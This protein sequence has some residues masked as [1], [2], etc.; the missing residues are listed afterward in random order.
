VVG[1]RPTVALVS[2]EVAPFGGGGIGRYV[3]ALAGLLADEF[4]V[5]IFTT[6]RHREAHD[7]ARR[8]RPGSLPPARLVFVREPRAW[9]ARS[10]FSRLHA[11]SARVHEA[12]L[13]E[14]EGRGPDLA[15]FA[16]FLGEGCVTVQAKRTGSPALLETAVCVRIHGSAEVYDVLDGFL[17]ADRERSFTHELERYSVRY[18]DALLWAGGDILGS[19][20]RFYG[21]GEL[22]P[23]RLVRHP[24]EWSAAA[25]PASLATGGPLRLLYL[26]RLERRKGVRELVDA[27]LGL[28]RTGWRLTMVG[29]DTETAPLGGSMRELLCLEIAGDDR[30]ELVESVPREQV[31]ALLDGHDALVVPS[32][33]E[34]WPYVALEAMARGRPLV[35][36]PTGGLC[37]LVADGASGWL[38]RD[39]SVDGLAGAL[40][41]LV[42]RPRLAREDHDAEAARGLFRT[43]TDPEPI[44]AA[45]RELCDHGPGARPRPADSEPPLVSIVIPYFELAEHVGEAVASAAAQTHPRC[46]LIVVNDGSFRAQDE[47]L[48]E[49]EARYELTLVAQPNSGLGAARNLGIELSRGEYVV[50]LDADNV[51]EPEFVARCVQALEADPEIVYVGSWLRYIDERGEPWKGTEEGLSPLGNSSRAV[52]SLNVAG[53]ACAVFRSSVF[54]SGLAYSTDVAGFEDWALYREMRRRGM[55]GHVIPERLIR[56]RMRADSMMRSLSAPREQW[57]RQAIEAHLAERSVRW[58]APR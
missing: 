32:R 56:Y 1:R 58:T 25:E 40:E 19:Y 17:P 4:E 50:P 18:A 12:L 51:L 43:L 55:I 13:A 10:S 46:E 20:E 27:L 41:P 31:P 23:A 21:R 54:R 9:D 34:C 36:T 7:A 15:E 29:A 42:E 45:Y 57:I 2:R 35:A 44:R 33:W 47:I 39:A 11:W 28:E 49:L 14:Y 48:L 38:A 22:A 16:D 26:G 3:S 5:T 24:F 8:E 30:I 37:E 53:D 52:E 6:S